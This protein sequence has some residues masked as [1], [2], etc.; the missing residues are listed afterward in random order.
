MQQVTG[1]L[2]I[3]GRMLV[4]GGIMDKGRRLIMVCLFRVFLRRRWGGHV[5]RV[6][7]VGWLTRGR[8]QGL[9]CDPSRPS[10]TT[11]NLSS[12]RVIILRL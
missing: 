12:L 7:L 1:A 4:D 3:Q 11:W 6:D 2:G 10:L 9:A 5:L 8:T